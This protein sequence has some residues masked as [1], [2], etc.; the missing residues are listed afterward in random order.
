M[1]RGLPEVTLDDSRAAAS[2]ELARAA[3]DPEPDEQDAAGQID[4]LIA[5]ATATLQGIDSRIASRSA[6]THGRGTADAM[7]GDELE[8]EVRM[9]LEVRAAAAERLGALLV[10][11]APSHARSHLDGEDQWMPAASQARPTASLGR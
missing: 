7:L 5:E 4:R 11:S 8:R 2:A 9:D 10:T 6:T 1:M 3:R